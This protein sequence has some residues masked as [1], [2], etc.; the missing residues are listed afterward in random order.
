MEN[1][2]HRG[3][4]TDE[5]ENSKNA[6]INTLKSPKY[7]GIEVDLRCSTDNTIF[8]IHDD[9]T[10]RI[11]DKNIKISENNC[12][13]ILDIKLHDGSYLLT[14]QM[15]MK[16]CKKYDKKIVFDL[17]S[18]DIYLIETII[19]YCKI[20]DIQMDRI[21]ILTWKS[22]IPC[23]LYKLVKIYYGH[24]DGPIGDETIIKIKNKHYRGVCIKFDNSIENIR[25]IEKFYDTGLDIYVYLEKDLVKDVYK[26]SK[27]IKCITY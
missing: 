22:D 21:K 17:K 9:N 24:A 26:Y 12:D 13:T 5:L 8:I 10:S 23:Y 7:S 18:N 3:V 15:F 27:I 20:Y 2:A 1:Y 4:I 25:F 6:I 14:L 16:I 11:S 19:N